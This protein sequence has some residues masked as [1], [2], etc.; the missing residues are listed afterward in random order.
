MSR[1]SGFSLIELIITLSIAAILATM[2]VPSFKQVMMNNRMAT[3]VNELVGALMLTRNEAIKQKSK[4]TL[5]KSSNGSSCG[6]TGWEDG[7]VMFVDADGDHDIDS[8]EDILRIYAAL[9]GDS[10]LTWNNGNHIIFKPDGSS[11]NGTFKL[12]DS[13]G[14]SKSHAVVISNTGRP[15][16]ETGSLT[17]P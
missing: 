2:A 9:P 15:H 16:I 13:R 1:N 3:Q 11:T 6:A 7:W 14:A 5:C 17:C 8:G 10:T 4:V 12:C